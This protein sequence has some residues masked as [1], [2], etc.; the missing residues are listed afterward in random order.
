M[1]S[2]DDELDR[3]MRQVEK[4]YSE[5]DVS[6]VSRK[7]ALK[8]TSLASDERDGKEKRPKG[9]ARLLMKGN[10]RKN[11]CLSGRTIGVSL[12]PQTRSRKRNKVKEPFSSHLASGELPCSAGS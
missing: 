4:G 11:S 3:G 7:P 6:V 10:R 5:G 2:S 1:R 12:Y 8:T 9:A